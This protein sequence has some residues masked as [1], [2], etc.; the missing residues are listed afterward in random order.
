MSPPVAFTERTGIHPE[1]R[2]CRASIDP[3]PNWQKRVEEYGLYYHTLR[4]EPY[5]DESACY[6]FTAY[7]I[8]TIEL[9]TQT[10]HD[11]CLELVQEV[12]DKRMFGLFLIPKEFEEYVIAL[13]GDR[14]SRR[15]T[16]A[17]TSP[18]TA[19]APPKM[20]EYNADTPDR[21]S[22]RRRSRSGSGSRT[23]TS[24]ATSSTASTSS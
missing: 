16:A 9:A 22:S 17:S 20:L 12:I 18:T 2:T 14:A 24:A 11:M 5:W 21:A 3:R 10:L 8:D 7:E 23:W 1:G 6:Q 15:S 4:G 19:S 13:V